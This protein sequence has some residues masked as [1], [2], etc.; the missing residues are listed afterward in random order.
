MPPRRKYRLS[1]EGLASLQ[2]AA[3]ANQPWT[4]S[5]GPRTEAGKAISRF[6]AWKRGFHRAE[7][8]RALDGIRRVRRLQR[9]IDQMGVWESYSPEKQDRM[10]GIIMGRLERWEAVPVRAARPLPPLRSPS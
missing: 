10:I 8:R 4:C 2:R 3:K 5:T 6:N 1:A 9:L 7:A